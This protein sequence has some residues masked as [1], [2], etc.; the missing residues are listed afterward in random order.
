MILFFSIITVL[1][2]LL[3]LALAFGFDTIE[4]FKV[5]DI[6][7]ETKF[8]VIIPFRNEAE[9]LPELLES[10]KLLKYPKSHY[11]II[12]VNDDSNDDSVE[13]ISKVL[14]TIS[15]TNEITQT[16]IRIINNIRTSNSPKKDAITS[17]ITIA[18]Y[19]WIVTTDAD[20]ILP[21]FWLDTI[22]CFIQKKHCKMVVAPVTYFKVNSF[23]K[24]FQIL[25]FLSL[26]VATIGGF[27][28]GRPFL[29]NGANLAY[30][31]ALFI[32]LDGF[33]G[34]D[35][36][37]SGDDIFLLQKAIKEDKK[38]VRFLKSRSAIV[39]TKPQQT[40]H[41]LISQ[42]K[43]WAA[44]TSSYNSVFG[45]LV[46][47]IVLLMNATLVSGLAL[48]LFG[49]L[50][51]TALLYVFVIKNLIDFLLIFKTTR[52][53]EQEKYLSSF[54]FSSLLYPFF[55]LFIVFISMFFKYKWKDRSFKK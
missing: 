32:A 18:K 29:C 7:A 45:K 35:A 36:I 1:Y 31:K 15:K 5:E 19:D 16:N 50:D 43:R 46:G 41:K 26:I 2:L 37:A 6:K 28:I 22:D 38:A 4:T 30:S 20:C 49:L 34:N 14:D 11:E 17:V 8:S 10:I 39:K 51:Y 44:K 33:K 42:R 55:S 13:I 3:I 24:R 54:L 53:F 9:N 12:F 23:L 47:L 27:G 21:K 40:L 48:A 25:D 52:F